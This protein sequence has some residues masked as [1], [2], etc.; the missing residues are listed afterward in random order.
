MEF[1]LIPLAFAAFFFIP[2][3]VHIIRG[4]TA[5]IVETFG[6]PSTD[7]M[8]PGLR[9][10]WPY[11]IQRVV[12]RIS[13]QLQQ[14]RADVEVKTRDNAFVR[15][16]VTVQYKA[17]NDPAGAVRAY[18]EMEN[19][20]SQITAFILNTVRQ[21]AASMTIAELFENR[22]RIE[23][24]VNETLSV[25]LR[26]VG[27]EIHA[28]LVDQPQPSPEVQTSFNRVIAAQRE[29]EAARM[30]AEASRIKQVGLAQ[31]EAESKKLQG[32]GIAQQRKAIAHGAKEA[33]DMLRKAMPD[34]S[35][36]E[37]LDFMLETNRLDTLSVVGQQGN[38][39][40]IDTAERNRPLADMSA[41][42]HSGISIGG[43]VLGFTFLTTSD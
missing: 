32:E 9:I 24:D 26:K 10:T 37:L 27:Y 13:L 40:I 43:G 20:E 41:A 1:L 22:S 11:P 5:A 8:M 28:V 7:A 23:D 6:K 2:S 30:E 29:A 17:D 25:R 3:M 19:P 14:I 38:T 12:G 15:L 31:A 18:Y 21:T 4:K 39:L 34:L 36:R 16:P 35:S 33:M 42:V